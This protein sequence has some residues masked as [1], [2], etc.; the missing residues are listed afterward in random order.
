MTSPVA[1]YQRVRKNLLYSN[2]DGALTDVATSTA[3]FTADGF[4]TLY[5]DAA[6][7][8]GAVHIPL[9]IGTPSVFDTEIVYIVGAGGGNVTIQRGR[10]GTAGI[11]HA[12]GDPY[13]LVP[14]VRDYPRANDF[15]MAFPVSNTNPT[16]A[17]TSGA[18]VALPHTGTMT[19]SVPAYK[20]DMLEVWFSLLAKVTVNTTRLFLDIKVDDGTAT[21]LIGDNAGGGSA[22]GLVYT[23]STDYVHLIARGSVCVQ[24][25]ADIVPVTI[26][27][28]YQSTGA[29]TFGCDDAS[30]TTAIAVQGGF[31]VQVAGVTMP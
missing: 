2:L 18:Y 3:V 17:S 22:A 15:F 25:D 28:V 9:M 26:T 1:N 6:A 16:F 7:L 29:G 21:Y 5:S 20:G 12:S 10:E 13:A 23:Q 30:P 27:P 24:N 14:T 8:Y 11:A 19:M 31:S 4:D